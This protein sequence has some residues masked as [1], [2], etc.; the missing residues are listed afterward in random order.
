MKNY[1]TV[2]VMQSNIS[3]VV[4]PK[5]WTGYTV[6]SVPPDTATYLEFKNTGWGSNV[7]GRVNWPRY[8]KA[9]TED[10]KRFT[11]DSFL[12]ASEWI[13]ETGVAFKATLN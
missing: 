2:M 3:A 8:K 6:G 10:A 5:G 13:S 9:S 4:V 11:V 7:A 12:N 1:S